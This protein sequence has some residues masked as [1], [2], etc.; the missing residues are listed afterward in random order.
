M[1]IVHQL[2]LLAVIKVTHCATFFILQQKHF[3]RELEGHKLH[4]IQICLV[5][6]VFVEKSSYFSL[7]SIISNIPFRTP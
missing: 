2:T 7:K 1:K 4:L 6:R 5:Y 3:Y